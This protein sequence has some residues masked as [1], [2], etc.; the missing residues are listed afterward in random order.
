MRYLANYSNQTIREVIDEINRKYFLPDIQRSFVWDKPDMVYKLYDSLMRGYPI[1]SFLFWKINK[2]A[3]KSNPAKIKKI[4]FVENNE[5][6]NK[7]DKTFDRDEYFL[8]LDGQQRLT[9]LYITL[10]GVYIERKKQ[11]E[12]FFNILSGKNEDDETLYQFKFLDSGQ[13]FQIKSFKDKNK[14]EQFGLWINVK[15]IYEI[16]KDD[17][18]SSL[19]KVIDNFNKELDA[20]GKSNPE[21]KN[22]K[23]NENNVMEKLHTLWSVLNEDKNIN[24]FEENKNNYDRVLDIFIRTNSGGIKLTYSDLLFSKIKLEWRNAKEEFK[25]LEDDINKNVFDFDEDFILKTCLV[26]YSK[27]Q[28]EV[29]YKVENFNSKRIEEIKND[30]KKISASIKQAVDLLS[31]YG[32]KHRKMLPSYNALIPIIYYVFRHPNGFSDENKRIIKKWLYRVLLTGVFGGQADTILYRMKRT[33]D[34]TKTELFPAEELN[35]EIKEMGKSLDINEEFLSQIKYNSGDSYL[36]LSLIYSELNFEPSY[37]GNIPEQD[38][39]FSRNELKTARYSM[40]DINDI[41]NI[42]YVIK[43]KNR[44]KS[45]MPFAKWIKELPQ[46]ERDKHLIPDGNWSVDSYRTFIKERRKLIFNKIKE[47]FN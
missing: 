35:R 33:I 25:E 45:D 31:E 39:I 23:I 27:K 3:L 34:E 19:N 28:E 36:L 10:K 15:R 6:E 1:G 32:I 22:I 4:K 9:S 26:L 7:E 30:W 5:E 24:Y 29:R 17:F 21:I 20:K 2:E 47:A 38:H 46:E 13:D 44:T 16:K 18:M 40:E 43:N 14:K 8:V 37:E 12:L 42:R 11:K 41:G